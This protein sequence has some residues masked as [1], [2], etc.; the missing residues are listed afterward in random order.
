MANSSPRRLDRT[1]EEPGE[2]DASCHPARQDY[3]LKG[4]LGYQHN[5]H[6]AEDGRKNSHSFLLLS[7]LF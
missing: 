6:N 2:A 4:V 1:I 3:R 7:S 5:Q